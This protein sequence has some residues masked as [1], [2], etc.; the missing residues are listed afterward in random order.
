M[1]R[2]HQF[3]V[4]GL[5]VGLSTCASTSARP[6]GADQS[7]GMVAVAGEGAKYWTPVART[8]RTGSGR[9]R[10]LSRPLERDR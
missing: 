10:R 9:R 2:R 5:T 3:V 1:R 7:V 6:Q 8:V 4:L